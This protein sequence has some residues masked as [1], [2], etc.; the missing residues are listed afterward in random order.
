[1]ATFLMAAF[2]GVFAILLFSVAMIIKAERFARYDAGLEQLDHSIDVDR[3]CA[4]H[5]HAYRLVQEGW[6]CGTCDEFIK[7]GHDWYGDESA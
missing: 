4:Q 5:G 6:R 2:L 1:M 7:T 3:F